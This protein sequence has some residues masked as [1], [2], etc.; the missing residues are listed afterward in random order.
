MNKP[1]NLL[2]DDGRLQLSRVRD[3]LSLGDI[4]VSA[5][6]LC[7]MPSDFRVGDVLSFILE[8]RGYTGTITEVSP[9]L[10][11]SVSYEID[12]LRLKEETNE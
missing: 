9:N 10:D 11:G 1:I 4:S 12:R 5:S 2:G 8:G 3:A 7:S 6:S